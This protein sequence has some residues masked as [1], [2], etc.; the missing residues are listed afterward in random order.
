MDGDDTAG[1]KRSG[2]CCGDLWIVEISGG[3][4]ITCS[5]KLCGINAKKNPINPIQNLSIV[6]PVHENTEEFMKL[7]IKFIVIW[8]Y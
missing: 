1:L 2:W 6:T 4:V 8:L 5:S 7:I 3:T